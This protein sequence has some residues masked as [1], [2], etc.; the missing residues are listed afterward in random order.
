MFELDVNISITLYLMSLMSS[1]DTCSS[2][3]DGLVLIWMPVI[4]AWLC[5][6]SSMHRIKRTYNMTSCAC[7]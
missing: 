2:L 3:L 5:I 6:V 4:L 1:L 7:G